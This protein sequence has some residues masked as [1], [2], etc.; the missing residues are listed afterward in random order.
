MVY[1]A[2]RAPDDPGGDRASFCR[3]QLNDR[4][5]GF[6]EVMGYRR[7]EVMKS[8][9]RSS[10]LYA[11]TPG[12]RHLDGA[13]W[14]SWA[15]MIFGVSA[16]GLLGALGPGFGQR[17]APISWR[18]GKRP[19]NMIAW[20]CSIKYRRTVK[21]A[22]YKAHGMTNPQYPCPCAV[23][24]LPSIYISIDRRSLPGAKTGLFQKAVGDRVIVWTGKIE[25]IVET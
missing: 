4:Y 17:P 11:V 18:G 7:V 9:V 16:P 1:F 5:P 3:K 15:G 8:T 21:G 22:G 6:V 13:G 12:F 20:I 23:R 19:E 10:R 2:R 14:G 24:R 25:L